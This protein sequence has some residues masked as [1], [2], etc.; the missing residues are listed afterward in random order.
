VLFNPAATS[1]AIAGLTAVCLTVG[2]W[3]FARS[4]TNR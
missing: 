2:T 1:A 3:M 4:E